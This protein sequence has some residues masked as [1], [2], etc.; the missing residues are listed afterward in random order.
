MTAMNDKKIY[1]WLQAWFPEL[2]YKKV[3]KEKQRRDF[4][5]FKAWM[6]VE[7]GGKKTRSFLMSVHPARLQNNTVASSAVLQDLNLNLDKMHFE[8]IQT[9]Q[10]I[11][12]HYELNQ[13][14]I[15]KNYAVHEQAAEML[16]SKI[17]QLLKEKKLKML[18]IY[19]DQYYWIAVPEHA[20]KV[21][22]FCKKFEKQFKADDV[23]IELFALQDCLQ[24]T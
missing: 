24:S 8:L 17:Y 9:I 16:L 1:K 21:N 5:H 23:R 4:E 2:D 14:N 13:Q 11:L 22:K 6:V 7:K 3:P 19:A 10:P 18:L 12:V 15:G 20:E